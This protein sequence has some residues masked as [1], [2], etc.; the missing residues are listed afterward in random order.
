MEHPLEITGRIQVYE[1]EEITKKKE[2][3]KKQP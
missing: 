1:S 2:E 3:T